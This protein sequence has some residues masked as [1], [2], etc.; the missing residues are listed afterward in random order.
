MKASA[1]TLI[2]AASVF[3]CWFNSP[4]PDQAE[5]SLLITNKPQSQLSQDRWL[6]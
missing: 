3:A 5:T 1:P 2:P 6:Q 4:D